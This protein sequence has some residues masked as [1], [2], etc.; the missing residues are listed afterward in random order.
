MTFT[1][2]G[3]WFP[4]TEPIN[5]PK[6]KN[7]LFKLQKR[8]RNQQADI[9]I[10]YPEENSERRIQEFKK[11]GKKVINFEDIESLIKDYPEY[12]L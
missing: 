4:G 12:F 11:Q 6:L 8:Q 10:V 7:I 2:T 3:H 1:V 5:K 9:L